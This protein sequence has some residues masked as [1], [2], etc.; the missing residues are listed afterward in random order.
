[1][2]AAG[3]SSASLNLPAGSAPTAPVAG[4][5]WNNAGVLQYR[6]SASTNRSLVST[7]QAGGMQLLKLTAA[8]TPAS[9]AAQSCTEQSFTVSGVSTTD[10]LLA[11]SQPSSSSPGANI[12]IGGWR[13]SAA[14]TVA[15]QFC[16]PSRSSSTP[17]PGT[18]TFALMR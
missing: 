10:M 4:D 16:N 5:V 17:V 7:T 9:V 18:Y 13:V 1:M 3:A 6:D 8:I 14:N 2:P 15:I 12:A 11:A